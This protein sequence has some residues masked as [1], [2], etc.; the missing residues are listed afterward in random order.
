[1]RAVERWLD[2][3]QAVLRLG[4]FVGIGTKGEAMSDPTWDVTSGQPCACVDEDAGVCDAL[5]RGLDVLVLREEADIDGDRCACHCHEPS[6]DD[7]G[8]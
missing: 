4:E 1:M 2:Q 8:E 5:R 6:E 3:M 7:N